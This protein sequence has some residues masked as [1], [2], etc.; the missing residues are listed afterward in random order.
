LKQ[1]ERFDSPT[2][3]AKS[4]RELSGKISS[5]ELK[6]PVAP[7][8][9][10]AK[11]EEV[12]QWRKDQGLP[13]KADGYIASL[14]LPNG[15]VPGEADKPLLEA[16]AADALKNNM[17]PD[18]YNQVVGWYFGMQDQLAAQREAADQTYHDQSVQALTQEWGKEFR[19]NQNAIASLMALAP[20]ELAAP[21]P[22]GKPVPGALLLEA[23][24]PDGTKLGDNP[25]A[26]KYLTH[27]ARE[28]NPASTVLPAAAGGGLTGVESRIAEIETKYMRAGQGTPEWQQY[29]KGETMQAEL[30]ELYGA[31]EKMKERKAA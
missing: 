10:D 11:P 31:R 7:P 27:L 24:L 12:A 18:T 28:I 8:G 3:L 6:A 20:A 17:S 26:L 30:R 22:D 23:R 14:K 5:G 25:V 15:M 2:A 1:L 13:E 16:F 4:Y 9:P 29:W 19:A 21:G